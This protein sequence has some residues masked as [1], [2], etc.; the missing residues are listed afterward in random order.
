[1]ADTTKTKSVLTV[2]A[3][4]SNRVREL[5]I[6]NGQL[7][8]I[9]DVQRIAFDFNDER[10]FYN[11]LTTLSSEYERLL[12]DNPLSGYYFCIETAVLWY[13]GSEWIQMTNQPN[14]DTIVF[15]GVELPELGKKNILY[16]DT[17]N[18]EI[19]VWDETRNSY[20]VVANCTNEITDEDIERLFD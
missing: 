2:V 7:I 8:F 19:S 5:P 18:K 20:I 14:E 6:S 10:V 1:M 4:T 9:K 15:I 16:T 17:S 13:Y 11:Q 3:T 12:L